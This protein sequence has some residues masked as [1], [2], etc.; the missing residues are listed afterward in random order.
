[1]NDIF[2][3][4]TIVSILLPIVIEAIKKAFGEEK[5]KETFCKMEIFCLFISFFIGIFVMVFYLIAT[6][7]TSALFIDKVKD[8]FIVIGF[9][10]MSGIGSQIGYDKVIKTIKDIYSIFKK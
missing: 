4:F 7:H 3:L 1:M 8:I 6:N 5:I 9:G 2:L 10:C